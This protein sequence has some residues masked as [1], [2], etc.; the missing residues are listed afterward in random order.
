MESEF[1]QCLI[2]ELVSNFAT[3]MRVS[4]KFDH[5]LHGATSEI[6]EV[7]SDGRLGDKPKAN[8]L[9]SKSFP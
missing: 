8:L 9:G 5:E 1:V 7:W 2:P 4:V 6:G 3:Q